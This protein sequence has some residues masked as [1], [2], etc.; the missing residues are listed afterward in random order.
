MIRARNRIIEVETIFIIAIALT[1]FRIIYQD[2]CLINFTHVKDRTCWYPLIFFCY[3][4]N[5]MN[6]IYIN[7]NAIRGSYCFWDFICIILCYQST[8][9]CWAYFI[10]PIGSNHITQHMHM[11]ILSID[12]LRRIILRPKLRT[13]YT[14][15]EHYN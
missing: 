1:Y 12:N 5:K 10:T 9:C 13:H 15:L 4:S 11:T 3:K 8:R 2:L 14:I 7:L 6:I